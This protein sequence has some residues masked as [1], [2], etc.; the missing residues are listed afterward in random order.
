MDSDTP[1]RKRSRDD[2]SN[3]N[4]LSSPQHTTTNNKKRRRK[5]NHAP[6]PQPPTHRHRYN[7]RPKANPNPNPNSGSAVVQQLKETGAENP[8]LFSKHELAAKL[9]DLAGKENGQGKYEGAALQLEPEEKLSKN[10]RRR[11]KNKNKNNALNNEVAE[12]EPTKHNHK[13]KEKKKSKRLLR[14]NV[15]ESNNYNSESTDEIPLLFVISREQAMPIH[16]IIP[17]VRELKH[18]SLE[19]PMMR[20]VNHA[21]CLVINSGNVRRGKVDTFTR[22]F[23]SFVGNSVTRL[24]NARFL[25]QG[26]DDLLGAYCVLPMDTSL[27]SVHKLVM[28]SV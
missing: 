4:P 16:L 6:T 11:R 27:I 7:T 20:C 24:Q 15:S 25:Q 12:A 26:E 21:K 9:V 13:N 17:G 5:H 2:H 1:N 14:S 8:Q 28:E 22:K 10:A 3:P 23:A 19:W 18:Y